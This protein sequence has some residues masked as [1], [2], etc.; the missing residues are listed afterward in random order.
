MPGTVCPNGHSVFDNASFCPTCGAPMKK[1]AV[2]P[3]D[4]TGVLCPNGHR[5]GSGVNFCPICGASMLPNQPTQTPVYQQPASQPKKHGCTYYI[6]IAFIIVV[7]LGAISRGIQ[8]ITNPSG[9][10]S[11]TKVAAAVASSARVVAIKSSTPVATLGP[12]KTAVSRITS[13]PTK[14]TTPSSTPTGGPS[15]TPAPTETP[16][17]TNTPEPTVTPIPPTAAPTPIVI[18]GNGPTA[19]DLV[20]LPSAISVAHFIY[21][22]ERNFIV[23]TWQGDNEDLLI[24]TIGSYDGTRPLIGDSVI[25]DIKAEGAWSITIDPIG[26]TDDPSFSGRGD[27]VSAAFMPPSKVAPWLITYTGERNFIVHC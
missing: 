23:H 18:Q 9:I 24:N 3:I 2:D 27:A 15:P 20:N 10:S 1:I 26:F 19:T 14:T 21:Q 4:G 25:F 13:E 5:V 11:P 7:V 6:V 8:S 22:G 12:I 16:A 17:P